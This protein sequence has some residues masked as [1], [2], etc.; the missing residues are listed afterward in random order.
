MS[1]TG[2]MSFITLGKVNVFS[3]GKKKSY[4]NKHNQYYIY[5]YIY[6]YYYYYYYYY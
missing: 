1:K 4:F 6:I 3:K 5:I 2:L